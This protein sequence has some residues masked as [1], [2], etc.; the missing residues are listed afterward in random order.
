MQK[1]TTAWLAKWLAKPNGPFTH[2]LL[3]GGKLY[4]PDQQH[5]LFLNEYSNAVARGHK[6]YVVE[7]RTPIFRLFVDFDFKPVPSKEIVDGAIKSAASVA[8]Y[9]FETEGPA[10]I[11]R[12][13]VDTP[14]KIG[15]HMTWNMVYVT[16]QTANS[17]RNHL[18]AKLVDACPEVD[19]KDVIDAS[20]YAGSG[21]R[22]PWSSKVNAPGVYTPHSTCAPDG[23][24]GTVD[25][26]CTASQIREWVRVTSIRAPGETA[27]KT[28]VVTSDNHE[29]E[30]TKD[31]AHTT[32]ENLLAHSEVL[33]KIQDTLPEHYKEQ[34][35]T[36]MHRYGDFCVVLRSSSKVCGNKGFTPHRTNTVYFVILKKGI[37][38][39]RCYC[40][41]DVV[42]ES[43][44][45]CTDYMSEP[46]AI[47]KD[48]L[49]LLW[50]TP[51]KETVNLLSILQKTRPPLKRAKKM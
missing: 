21:L 15:V 1:K 7:S 23:S 3:D 28:C 27:T 37:A 43:G 49:E 29:A 20:V 18:V 9:Y 32:S 17:F 42:R 6:L 51:S 11:L 47:P 5:N 31:K 41:K 24:V 14:G 34:Q 39:Q 44:V 16:T 40:R 38:Y 10:V 19:W 33:Q 4:V 48:T 2:L 45:T 22:M 8:G 30:T 46:W 50:P 35:F 12:K 36:G 13:D 26:I 25:N